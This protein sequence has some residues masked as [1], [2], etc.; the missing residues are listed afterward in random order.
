MRL[1]ELT[2]GDTVKDWRSELSFSVA[3]TDHPG[4]DGVVLVCDNVIRC[5]A[6]DA[7]EPDAGGRFPFDSI[8]QFG[9]N[10]YALSNLNQWLNS[11]ET[12]WYHPSHDTDTPPI[13]KNLR[14]NEQPN[15]EANGFL[16]ELTPA[17]VAAM[18]ESEVPVLV[19]TAN[20]RGGVRNGEG[21]SV[22]PEPHGDRH[23]RRVRF[24]RGDSTA[25]F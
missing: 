12:F 11:G 19:R 24:C 7:A 16:R 20:E 18:R 17:F 2:I 9:R 13:G 3:A 4:Y 14:Y 6:F 8:D 5:A 23:G 15:A 21:E 22:S 1:H 25:L 10:N